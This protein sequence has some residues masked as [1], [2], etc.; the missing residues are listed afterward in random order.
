M[1]RRIGI[2]NAEIAV[3]AL[4]R[5]SEGREITGHVGIGCCG[6][7]SWEWTSI[8]CAC[9]GGAC[10][11]RSWRCRGGLGVAARRARA[12]K[13]GGE[14]L[15]N[16]DQLLETVHVHQ[17][18]DVLVGVG[19]CGRVLILHLGH[20]QRKKVVGGDRGRRTV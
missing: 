2:W 18:V 17:L 1:R 19:I 12:P 10:S 3:S 5:G 14:I 16:V 6:F 20:Q 9:A 7:D 11:V 13:R 8:L 15:I 4:G